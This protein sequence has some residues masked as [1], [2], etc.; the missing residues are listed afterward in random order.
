MT[1]ERTLSLRS[2]KELHEATRPFAKESRV[3]SWW[4]TGSTFLLLAVALTA[5][6]YT[7][8]GLKRY[9]YRKKRSEKAVQV[10]KD[11]VEKAKVE[12]QGILKILGRTTV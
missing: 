7:I 1:S 2:G 6:G 8:A 3:K 5:A 4:F 10:P 9:W 12:L 11:R